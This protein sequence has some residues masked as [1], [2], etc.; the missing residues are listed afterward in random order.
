[1]PGGEEDEVV[2]GA[3]P[4]REHLEGLQDVGAGGV[5][6]ENGLGVDIFPAVAHCRQRSQLQSHVAGILGGIVEG[7][8]FVPLLVDADNQDMEAHCVGRLDWK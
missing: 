4:L 3:N 7:T 6:V 8:A 5:P 1:M 2:G